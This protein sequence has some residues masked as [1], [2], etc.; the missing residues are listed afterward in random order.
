M[1]PMGVSRFTVPQD[2]HVR[3]F[4]EE[5]VLLDLARGE[6]FTLDEVGAR[7]WEGLDQGK[8][9]AEV[10]AA[11]VLDYDTDVLR[12]EHDVVAL[13]DELLGR[14]LLVERS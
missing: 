5:L 2:V 4:H 10:V 14:H 9:V 13:V 8:S 3:R 11:L 12:L 6:Y 1:Q 7:V